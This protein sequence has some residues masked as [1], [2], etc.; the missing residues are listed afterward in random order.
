MTSIKKYLKSYIYKR[1][2]VSLHQ[3]FCATEDYNKEYNKNIKQST[4][5]R[6]MREAVNEVSKDATRRIDAV[7]NA[8]GEIIGYE[9]VNLSSFNFVETYDLPEEKLEDYKH[10]AKIMRQQVLFD[11]S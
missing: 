1:G 11:L 3:I 8:K 9:V 2:R 10:D 6:K 5:E 7:R 4:A